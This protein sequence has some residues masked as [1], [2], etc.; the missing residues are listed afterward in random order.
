MKIFIVTSFDECENNSYYTTALDKFFGRNGHE[1]ILSAAEADMIVITTC[2][3]DEEREAGALKVLNHY[4][5]KYAGSK[6]VVITGCLPKINPEAV[7]IKGVTVIDL[8][9]L[10]KFDELIDSEFPFRDVKANELNE[11]VVRRGYRDDYYI[12][13]CQGC[14]QACSYCAIKKAKGFA[15]SK[16]AAEIE[17]EIKAGLD[18]G[19]RKFVLL[20]DDCGSYG[21]DA[22]TD[23]A[24][25]LNRITRI[26]P[27][28]RFNIHYI[29]PQKLIDLYETINKEVWRNIY[30]MN[31]PIQSM[32]DRV[33]GLMN[34]KYDTAR[35]LEIAGEIKSINKDIH[36]TTHIIY[37][38]PSEAPAETYKAL[39]L[40]DYFDEVMF[41]QYS[42][43]IGTPASKLPGKLTEA[44][45][46][47]RVRYLH[48]KCYGTDK[49]YVA[50]T[51]DYFA[52]KHF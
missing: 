51:R 2:A 46:F 6:P 50:N 20:A 5:R 3:F 10:D 15:R 13:I 18:R 14:A 45:M 37:G 29:Y 39:V 35:L 25:L 43:K 8:Q 32:S 41:F 33:L 42:D 31:V 27:K 7:D 24:A 38:F 4:A 47:E 36:L 40:G 44:E 9:H 23:F 52:Q 1:V 22:K 34:R 19:Y 16:P 12:V 48:Q 17:K 49:M 26:D 11:N 30:F 21:L 28:A